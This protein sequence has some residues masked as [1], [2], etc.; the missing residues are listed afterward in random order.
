MV[1]GPL[2][3]WGWS[4]W[5]YGGLGLRD[6]GAGAGG[7]MGGVVLRALGLELVGI[8][9]EWE[10]RSVGL[11]WRSVGLSWRWRS[12]SGGVWTLAEEEEEE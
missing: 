9:E 3:N 10:W 11:S 6:S 1:A 7:Y 5:V 12:W 2:G 8:W 4:W